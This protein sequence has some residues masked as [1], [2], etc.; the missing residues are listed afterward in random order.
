MEFVAKS[1][2]VRWWP[3]SKTADQLS[4]SIA[5]LRLRLLLPESPLSLWTLAQ[6][7][8]RSHHMSLDKKFAQLVSNG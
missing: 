6:W 4:H 7:H 1:L 3:I 2:P 8:T 5:M